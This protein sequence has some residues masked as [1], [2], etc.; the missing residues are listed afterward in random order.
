MF[1]PFPEVLLESGSGTALL[2]DSTTEALGRTGVLVL[3]RQVGVV[4][5]LELADHDGAAAE[6]DLDRWNYLCSSMYLGSS[7]RGELK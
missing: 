2:S 3:E 6:L 4:V 7:V 1:H 5:G